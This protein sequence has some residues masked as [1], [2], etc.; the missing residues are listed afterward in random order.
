M[1]TQV[2]ATNP[3]E[4]LRIAAYQRGWNDAQGNRPRAGVTDPS[5]HQGYT[6][7]KSMRERVNTYF[8]KV[9]S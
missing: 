9:Q 3:A 5:Y 6:S 7:A 1:E 2:T 4:A 8:D